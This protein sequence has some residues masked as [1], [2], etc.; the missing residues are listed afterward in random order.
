MTR[1]VEKS[2]F[3]LGRELELFESEFAA[4]CG[5]KC[6]VGVDSGLSALELVLHAWGIGAGDEVITAANT[7]IATALAISSTGAT[8]VLVD[9]DPHTHNIDPEAMRSAITPRT[10]A[11][12]PVHLYGRPAEMDAIN[13]IAAQYDVA[14]LEDAC[15]A[16]GA[17]Y[18]GR[19]AGSLGHAAGFSFY[20]GK[21]LGAYGD[22]GAI[23][24]NDE[25]LARQLRTMRNYGQSEKYIHGIRGSNRRL[26]TLQAA[27]LRVK[28]RHLDEW[29]KLRTQHAS[30]YYDLLFGASVLLPQISDHMQ[31]AWHLY[32]I[33]TPFRN[34]M[35]VRLSDH[36]IA[37][38]MHY[39]VPI[40][41]QAAYADAGYRRG[42]F[43]ITE[44]LADE[45]LSLP[46]YAE[47]TYCSM[48]RIAAAV[49]STPGIKRSP[50]SLVAPG[51]VPSRAAYDTQ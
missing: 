10:R 13:E 22:G 16:H 25:A 47:L 37:T 9:V 23:V 7:F 39:P 40:H 35:R 28:L 17:K 20:P 5:A 32:V 44:K 36:G 27:V 41:M 26:D 30:N 50:V 3:I 18:K 24:T 2:D 31:S 19:R 45:I 38:G 42:D 8:P 46:M 1:V 12:V 6:C 51:Y 11:V 14:V 49:M 21:N 15:Q 29:N 34:A 43:P 33:R 48:E 4:F